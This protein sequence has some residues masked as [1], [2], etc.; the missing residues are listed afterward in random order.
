M[1]E[2]D[3]HLPGDNLGRYD[4]FDDSNDSAIAKHSKIPRAARMGGCQSC[5]HVPYAHLPV[6]MLRLMT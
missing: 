5:R 1:C 3:K 6:G 4:C 2:K